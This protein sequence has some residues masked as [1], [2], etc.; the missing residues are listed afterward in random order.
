MA[1]DASPEPSQVF[2]WIPETPILGKIAILVGIWALIVDVVNISI[3]AYASGQK[4]V[5][6]GF[7]TYG[8]LAEN[9]FTAHNGIEVSLGDVVFTIIAIIILGFGTLILNKTE[10][11]GVTSWISSLVSSERWSPLFDFSKGLNVTLG[12][13]LLITGISF[14]FGW[15][16]ANNT[17]VDPGIYAVCIPL[18]GFGSV[19]PLL[20]SNQEES[21]N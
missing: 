21:E 16:I 15:S 6:A 8:T 18:I 19:L 2:D 4:V 7:V 17:W 5:W 3:G 14:Y 13:W 9:T 10:E 1:E 20:E 11:G 12:S